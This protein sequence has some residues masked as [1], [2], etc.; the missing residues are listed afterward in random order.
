VEVECNGDFE[1]CGGFT[2]ELSMN[3]VANEIYIIRVGGFGDGSSGV[4]QIVIGGDNCHDIQ[5]VGDTDENGEVDVL[6]LLLIID[7]WGEVDSIQ[8]DI[9]EDGI[10]GLGDILLILQNW[11]HCQ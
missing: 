7:H 10:V 11:G 2:S 4:G 1:D 9:D 8:Y 6:D 3:V 5:C